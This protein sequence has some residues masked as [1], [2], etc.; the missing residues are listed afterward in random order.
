MRNNGNILPLPSLKVRTHAMDGKPVAVV[1]VYP[2]QSPLVRDQGRT[3]VRVRPTVR[4]ATPEEERR[5]D[6]RTRAG[7][8][9][10]DMRPAVG[11]RR[12]DLDLE[13][14]RRQYLPRDIA[15]EVLGQNAGTLPPATAF[16]AVTWQRDSARAA[17]LA[18]GQ[19]PQSWHPAHTCNSFVWMAGS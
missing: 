1:T 7:S 8:L 5:L 17:L 4:L 12:Q 11:A 16:T 18:F 19:D 14:L 13:Y 3:W 15:P 2:T 10:L 6:E 9:P